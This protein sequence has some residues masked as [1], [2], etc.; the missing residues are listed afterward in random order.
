MFDP[1]NLNEEEFDQ[2]DELEEQPV[3]ETE[4]TEEPANEAEEEPQEEP[5]QAEEEEEEPV[6]EETEEDILSKFLE[7]P[8]ETL[9]QLVEQKL[10][11]KLEETQKIAMEEQ[12]KYNTFL[13]QKE[14]LKSTYAP[15]Y[16]EIMTDEVLE[17]IANNPEVAADIYNSENIAEKAY[18][19]AKF[20]TTNPTLKQIESLFVEKKKAPKPI[21]GGNKVQ[22]EPEYLDP[23]SVDLDDL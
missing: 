5:A 14:E 19:F 13:Q 6:E 7:N 23:D 2:L 15:D 4:E 12:E 8:E 9:E 1:E 16:D 21:G 11:Q 3:E 20:G 17:K 10:Q 22:F 18:Y